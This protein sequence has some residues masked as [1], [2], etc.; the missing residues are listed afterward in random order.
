MQE[1]VNL[2]N[3]H[4]DN[5]LINNSA[6]ELQNFLREHNLSGLEMLFYENW[7]EQIHKKDF[8]KGVHLNF[9]PNWLDFWLDNKKA[10]IKEYGDLERAYGIY[11]G[12]TKSD[13]LNLYQDNIIKALEAQPEYLVFH[14]AQARPSEVFHWNFNYDS[15]MVI[16]NSIEVLQELMPI[17]P[18]NTK[19]LLENLWWPGLTLQKKDLVETIFTKLKYDNLGLI[20][21]TG[22]LMN[23]NAN[24]K[25]QEKADKSLN[26]G[27]A[28]LKIQDDIKIVEHYLNIAEIRKEK[29][30]PYKF[31]NFMTRALADYDYTTLELEEKEKP[32]DD[33]PETDKKQYYEIVRIN[34]EA[35]H[36][37]ETEQDIDSMQT[38]NYAIKSFLSSNILLYMVIIIVITGTIVSEEYSKGTI[39][40]LLVKPYK[41]STILLSKLFVILIMILIIYLILFIAQVL[42][43]G[44]SCDFK[45]ISQPV[46]EYNISVGQL[47]KYNLFY[48]SIR[49]FIYI[50]PY[51][52]IFVLFT[53]A[54]S[55]ITTSSAAAISLGM[56]SFMAT[57]FI[58][59]ILMAFPKDWMKYIP[60]LY[61]DFRKFISPGY[62]PT[63]RI[64]LKMSI[65]ITVATMLL[66]LIPT[67]IV[68]NKKDIKNI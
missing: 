37:L 27:S 2:S 40:N 9:W 60:T 51:I 14:V 26:L 3:Y 52:L 15:S 10:L 28:I 6:E 23:T 22:H 7:D 68:F 44:V 18:S 43:A 4:L 55:T 1:L 64:N 58:N 61:W 67:F 17:I 65:I 46:V 11:G 66:F 49:E 12:K 32:K 31:D 21:D 39:K 53:F 57:Q 19:L 42:I 35:K 25:N 38:A 33:A 50:L 24:L 62:N 41:R 47:Q 36:K 29:K 54:V 48:Y 59:S 56:V 20:L 13:W 34:E 63:S 30:I 8:V 16:E 45:T 5:L